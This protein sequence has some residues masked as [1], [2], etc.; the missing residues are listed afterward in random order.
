MSKTGLL[1]SQQITESNKK[2]LKLNNKINSISNVQP[3]DQPNKLIIIISLIIEDDVF[4]INSWLE[5]AKSIWKVLKVKA[6]TE[7]E[8]LKSKHIKEAVERRYEYLKLNP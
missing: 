8:L 4:F 1:S 2:I 5:S 7:L 6:K 3:N